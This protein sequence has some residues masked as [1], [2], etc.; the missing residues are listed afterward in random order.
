MATLSAAVI[1]MQQTLSEKFGIPTFDLTGKVSTIPLTRPLNTDINVNTGSTGLSVKAF[2]DLLKKF[3]PTEA[4][5]PTK[6]VF[7]RDGFVYTSPTSSP[8][9]EGEVEL[10]DRNIQTSLSTTFQQYSP[11]IILGGLALVA[12]TLLKK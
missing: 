7:T 5:I 10:K 11:Y 1:K 4:L 3:T 9:V 8:L 2:N 12:L 6:T